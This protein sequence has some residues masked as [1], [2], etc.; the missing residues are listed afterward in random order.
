MQILMNH[1]FLEFKC[2]MLFKKDFQEFIVFDFNDKMKKIQ[3]RKN[4]M[5][6]C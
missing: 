2:F 6:F 3:M 5:R 4:A 1:V